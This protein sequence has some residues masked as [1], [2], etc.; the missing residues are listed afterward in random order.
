[1]AKYKVTGSVSYCK[2]VDD[3]VELEVEASNEDGAIETALDKLF[4]SDG[5]R[6]L[7]EDSL[8]TELIEEE[9]NG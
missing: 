8:E 1:M 2:P 7:I 6:L 4:G 5:W 9:V 3:E